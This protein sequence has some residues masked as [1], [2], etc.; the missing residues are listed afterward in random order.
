MD[1]SVALNAAIAASKGFKGVRSGEIAEEN[2]R[3]NYS[4]KRKY[5]D[6]KDEKLSET[7]KFV[8]GIAS[9]VFN[10]MYDLIDQR[11]PRGLFFGNE[12]A[13]TLHSEICGDRGSPPQLNYCI[14]AS[15][16]TYGFLSAWVLGIWYEFKRN[17]IDAKFA[18]SI[19]DEVWYTCPI[20]QAEKAAYWVMIA[21]ARTWALL[22][23]K[24]NIFDMPIVRAFPS[25]ISIDPILRKSPTSSTKTP[26]FPDFKPG[27][28]VTFSYFI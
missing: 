27:R 8:K 17:N 21:Y 5:K 4:K 18:I 11:P 10:K 19:H 23:H 3:T 22:H 12:W 16:S 13:K 2:R 28:E 26:T 7:D 6:K 15:C 1:Y 25:S 24:L 20:E 9:D 14:Q